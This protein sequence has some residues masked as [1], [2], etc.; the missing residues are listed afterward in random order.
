[1]SSLSPQQLDNILAALRL[2]QNLG[3]EDP[4]VKEMPHFIDSDPL[5][6]EGIDELCQQL[7]LGYAHA[8]HDDQLD[9]RRLAIVNLAQENNMTDDLQIYEDAK[10]SEGEDNGCFV[11]AWVWQSF[12]DT[13][14]DKNVEKTATAEQEA[15]IEGLECTLCTD[16]SCA[17][18]QEEIRMHNLP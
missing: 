17:W 13:P 11:E 14:F 6:S 9:E 7:I 15:F 8:T 10:T 5:T 18:C 2:M 4:T 3:P 1:M 16:G 12:V